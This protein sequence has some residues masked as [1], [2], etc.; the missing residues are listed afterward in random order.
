M[1]ENIEVLSLRANQHD[2]I[3][4]QYRSNIYTMEL[5]F[6]LLI[7]MMEEKGFLALE[8]FDKR[9]PIYLK[10]DV[11]IIGSDGVMEGTL[12]VRFYN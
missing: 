6:N 4:D 3:L 12:A 11:G 7:K 5:K 8:E 9:W 2:M 10:N 1:A